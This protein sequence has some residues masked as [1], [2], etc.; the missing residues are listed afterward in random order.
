VEA[1]RL[2]NISNPMKVMPLLSSILD[3]ITMIV[4]FAKA[5]PGKYFKSLITLILF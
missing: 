5:S 2:W 3:M 4:G 1:K